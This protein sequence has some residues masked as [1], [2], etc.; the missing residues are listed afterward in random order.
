M[1]QVLKLKS[2]GLVY[3][4]QCYCKDTMLSVLL[5]PLGGSTKRSVRLCAVALS[6]FRHVKTTYSK[7]N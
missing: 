1:L 2:G 6:F 7:A 3:E 4:L 5:Q